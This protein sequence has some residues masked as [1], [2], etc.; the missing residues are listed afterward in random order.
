[1]QFLIWN[2]WESERIGEITF[3]NTF[4]MKIPHGTL[5]GSDGKLPC[6]EQLLGKLQG[7]ELK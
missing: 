6:L 3:T 7:S 4:K 5:A 2:T 1:M